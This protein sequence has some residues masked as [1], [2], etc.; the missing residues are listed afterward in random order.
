MLVGYQISS[1][2]L[3]L[4]HQAV[5]ETKSKCHCFAGI[6]IINIDGLQVQYNIQSMDQN[7]KRSNERTGLCSMS[8][9]KVLYARLGCRFLFGRENVTKSEGFNKSFP[10]NKQ[11]I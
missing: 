2:F 6:K 1:E 8:S 4:G 5:A 3:L 10:I 7:Q 9:W 11:T